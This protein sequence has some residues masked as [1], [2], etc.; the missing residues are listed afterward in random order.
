MKK[1]LCAA[2]LLIAFTTAVIAQAPKALKK[3]L[4]L[5]MPKTVDDDMPG[6]RGASIVWHPVQKNIT[7][8]LQAT[9]H[10][11][12]RCLMLQAKRLSAE[13][14]STQA[15]TRGLWYNTVTKK[16]MR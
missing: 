8:L 7:H 6:T 15:D 3:V 11:Q 10:T 1:L 5:K 9:W 16:N 12:W 13:D 14:A 4:E 2:A